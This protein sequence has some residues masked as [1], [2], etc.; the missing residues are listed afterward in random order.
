MDQEQ[1]GS[2]W[3]KKR[4]DILLD[5]IGMRTAEADALP[6]TFSFMIWAFW[7]HDLYDRKIDDHGG[8]NFHRAGEAGPLRHLM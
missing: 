4:R 6:F 8:G 1:G 2:G 5:G 3:L 7:L